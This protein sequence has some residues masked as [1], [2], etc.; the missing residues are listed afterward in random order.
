MKTI[1]LRG[2]PKQINKM[3]NNYRQRRFNDDVENEYKNLK[4]KDGTCPVKIMEEKEFA[5]DAALDL[6]AEQMIENE[7]DEM[8][9]EEHGKH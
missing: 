2:T 1:K 8:V 3:L 5:Y 4:S 6:K 7:I 9:L